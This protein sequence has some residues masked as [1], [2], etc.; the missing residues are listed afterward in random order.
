MQVCQPAACT[1]HNIETWVSQIGS[2]RTTPRI[3]FALLVIHQLSVRRALRAELL[4]TTAFP[5]TAA[6]LTF[7]IRERRIRVAQVIAT[8]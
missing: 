3:A 6:L 1:R 5:S 4:R 2:S 7:V 8:E